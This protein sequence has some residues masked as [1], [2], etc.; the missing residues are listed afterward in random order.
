MKNY[1]LK[2]FL[3]A[4]VLL[5]GLILSTPL[6]AQSKSITFAKSNVTVKDVMGVIADQTE[7][8]FIYEVNDVNL[9]RVVSVDFKS[10]NLSTALSTLFAGTDLKS[11]VKGEHIVLSKSATKAISGPVT[12]T[13]IVKDA[14]G[15]AVI[16]AAIVDLATAN[17]AS[18]NVDGSYMITVDAGTKLEV[19]Y[20]GYETAKF[21][22]S[23]SKSI[24]DITLND[25]SVV[26]DEVVVTALGIKRKTKAL[27]YSVQKVSADEV[28]TN[29]SANFM[30][31]LSG[32]VAGLQINS[33]AGPGGATKVVMRGAKSLTKSNNALYVID[34][35]PILNVSADEV[36]GLHSSVASGEGISDIN[37]DDIASMS[38][39]TGPAAA[40]LYGSSAANGAVL[41]TTKR[42]VEGRAKVTFSHN[43]DFS[44]PFVL[45]E[46]QSRY[47][48][49]Q[50]EFSS[51]G[52]KLDT[53][54]NY[55]PADFF[56]TGY[57]TT[58][59]ISVSGGSA[60]NQMFASASNT[61]AEGI[62]PGNEYER[63]NFTIRNTTKFF[64]DRLTLD[65]GVSYVKQSDKNMPGQ[66]FYFNPLIPVYLFPRGENFD[67]VRL[68]ERYDE[69]TGVMTQF[70]PYGQE[71]G[72]NMQNPY[73][74]VN[75]NTFEN[76]KDRYMMNAGLT[77]EVTDWLDLSGRVR[78]DNSNTRHDKKLYASTIGAYSNKKGFYRTYKKDDK[79][80]YADVMASVMKYW[81]DFDLTANVGASIQDLRQDLN[82]ASG[83]LAYE[84][85][86]FALANISKTKLGVEQRGWR[87][88]Q[89]SVFASAELGWKGMLYFTGTFRADWASQL[90]NTENMGFPYSSVGFS[91]V[92]SEMVEMPDWIN[93]LKI[94]GSYASV[95]SPISRF[96]SIPTYGW[97]GSGLESNTSLAATQ[98]FPERTKSFEAGV[99]AR[100]F[101]SNFT[102]DASF[103]KSNTYNQTFFP[104]ASGG[105]GY[106]NFIAQ[107]GDVS[108][109]GIEAMVNYDR[110]WGAFNWSSTLTYSMNRNKIEKL[111]RGYRDPFTGKD[112]NIPELNVMIAGDYRVI[113]T[114]GGTIGD[115]YSSS[116][117]RED[118]QGNIYATASGQVSIVDEVVKLGSVAPDFNMSFSNNFSYKGINLSLMVTGRFGGIV[119]SPT[120][121]YLDNYG[122]SEASAMAR[123]NGGVPVNNGLMDSR[124]FYE[125]IGGGETGMLSYYTYD[126]TNIRLQELVLGYTLP[127]KWFNDK[128]GMTVSFVGRNL[129]ML[130]NS[131]PFDP[132]AIVNT[133]TF[134]QG[135]DLF[136]QPSTRNLGFSVKIQF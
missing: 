60:K 36:S 76:T 3:F 118:H 42:G 115:V 46:F 68:Y 30:S 97:V 110:N 87:E 43:T 122:V 70:W 2:I 91:A 100:L 49:K 53:P 101:D 81:G 10:Q 136:M 20:I 17:G 107:G 51:W 25:S 124:Y 35:V 121:A 23:G 67:N 61:M 84:Y 116:R 108:N 117:L 15:L 132:E 89:Q 48:N 33:A 22:V 6:Y 80:I 82:G 7:M 74:A 88:Q 86:F 123:D 128:V 8:T 135:V 62:M 19:S 47:G 79:Q 127:K 18:T 114:E 27:G 92:I 38:I 34:G 112:V 59:S 45:P 99:N 130:Y 119:M 109:W 129:L 40:A 113:L 58:T 26:V 85:N 28:T 39:L 13:G 63:S 16:G 106:K 37:P 104:Q 78:V 94:R 126:A 50:G 56:Q 4:A 133:G 9:D 96:I 11:T 21:L 29:K 54:S 55:N 14:S 12:I 64:K 57:N 95:G 44:D 69:G 131:A 103:Y 1:Y 111:L 83:H 65:L 52:A 32:K 105:S 98:L 66:G 24:Y 71:G 41:I 134:Y 120:Q 77:L 90:A 125:T 5:Q 75:K 73:W 102:L 72:L 31:S 93:F